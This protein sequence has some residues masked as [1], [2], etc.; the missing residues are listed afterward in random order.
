MELSPVPKGGLQNKNL[1]Y[2]VLA[3]GQVAG[4]NWR[5]FEESAGDGL[6][7][8]QERKKSYSKEKDVITM[9]M[10]HGCL[11]DNEPLDLPEEISRYKV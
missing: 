1:K 6:K 7:D 8:N 4:R 10:Q 5:D 9:N 3:L 11:S 2:V